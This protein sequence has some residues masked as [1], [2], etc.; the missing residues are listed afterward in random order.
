MISEALC[1]GMQAQ[2][3]LGGQL[4]PLASVASNT[5]TNG[6][7][8][9]ASSGPDIDDVLKA[10]MGLL[11]KLDANLVS[12][13][14]TT[15]AA[16]VSAPDTIFAVNDPTGSMCNAFV[17]NV[18]F[19][20][21]DESESEFAE[22]YSPLK[23]YESILDVASV[24]KDTAKIL[25]R[26]LAT[27]QTS[28]ER[29]G[30]IDKIIAKLPDNDF[31]ASVKSGL[32]KYKQFYAEI[33]RV[34]TEDNLKKIGKEASGVFKKDEDKARAGLIS[35]YAE[36][37]RI[38]KEVHTIF[39]NAV[40]DPFNM[41][42]I[43]N[44]PG[45]LAKQIGEKRDRQT[46]VRTSLEQ[47]PLPEFNDIKEE[48]EGIFQELPGKIAEFKALKATDT[49]LLSAYILDYQTHDY[50]K[51]I[52]R[53]YDDVV[54]FN[55]NLSPTAQ[56]IASI[57]Q[58][59]QTANIGN[60]R[61]LITGDK[62]KLDM[63]VEKFKK[64]TIV[65]LDSLDK[66]R[67]TAV[68]NA[69]PSVQLVIKSA[70]EVLR[71]RIDEKRKELEEVTK[72]Y[73]KVLEL[74]DVYNAL[75][76]TV[77]IERIDKEVQRKQQMK[78]A[79]IEYA[80]KEA[81]AVIDPLLTSAA[82]AKQKVD[83]DMA[84]MTAVPADPQITQI[85]QAA[86]AQ[87]TAFNAAY[88]ASLTAK[89]GFDAAMTTGDITQPVETIKSKST[90]IKRTSSEITNLRLDYETAKQAFD[91]NQ[92]TQLQTR[93]AAAQ[94]A[95]QAAAATAGGITAAQTATIAQLQT[96]IARLTAADVAHTTT[97]VQ[98]QAAVA[99]AAAAAAANAPTINKA[100]NE[101]YIRAYLTD[102]ITQLV[103]KTGLPIAN[104][105]G[106]IDS[107]IRKINAITPFNGQIINL[108]NVITSD[109]LKNILIQL[110]ADIIT[111][112]PLAPVFTPTEIGTIVTNYIEGAAEIVANAAVNP[113]VVGR[114]EILAHPLPAMRGGGRHRVTR[115]RLTGSKRRK[116]Y[117]RRGKNRRHQ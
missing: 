60:L 28:L 77:E 67:I 75:L 74:I 99:A 114:A 103:A 91:G 50:I 22:I 73:V 85:I 95:A 71:Q 116:T 112:N 29:T 104:V 12:D 53:V 4:S 66:Q 101:S 16:P 111:A 31:T 46:P 109:T 10:V 45:G 52:K 34:T 54:T 64:Q 8:S 19:S 9:V 81:L 86:T 107:Y 82:A 15:V 93:L 78:M 80:K 47:A 1:R 100:A 55:N 5:G 61:T 68:N 56:D 18:G 44:T 6:L 13:A 63:M 24:S 117:V 72:P 76:D 21:L 40:A 102:I 41:H 3:P 79:D 26:I 36:T 69:M 39:V 7:S 32:E 49:I 25:K 105:P 98:L 35:V 38:A 106:K 43:Y 90:D 42:I 70:N 96:D 30:S 115:R 87:Q 65:K 110:Q 23:L 58:R 83:I 33:D 59:I 20:F 108:S 113:P 14:A 97:I 88:Q 84:A 89:T 48:L 2:Q 51:E 57:K 92:L 94:A 27:R 17:S 11:S 62:Q 37:F